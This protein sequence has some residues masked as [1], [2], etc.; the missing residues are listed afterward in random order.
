MV[1]WTG[2]VGCSLALLLGCCVPTECLLVLEVRILRFVGGRRVRDEDLCVPLEWG[3]R[4]K[5]NYSRFPAMELGMIL[6][7]GCILGAAVQMWV[8]LQPICRPKRRGPLAGSAHWGWGLG[9]SSK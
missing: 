1:M 2:A 6:V 5:E 7:L 3:Q 8:C 4:G 9:Q